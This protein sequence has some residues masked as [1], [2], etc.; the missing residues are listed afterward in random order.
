[1]TA[2]A[3]RVM[4]AT[5]VVTSAVRDTLIPMSHHGLQ[6]RDATRFCVAVYAFA[7]ILIDVAYALHLA[8]GGTSIE[9]LEFASTLFFFMIWAPLVPLVVLAARRFPFAPGRRLRTIEIHLAL[10]LALS[11]VTLFAHKLLFCPSNDWFGCVTYY[12]AEA[13]LARWIGLDLFLYAAVLAGIWI[14]DSIDVKRQTELRASTIEL[15]IA[16]A[17]LKLVNTQVNP[18]FLQKTFDWLASE[19]RRDPARA[20]ALMTTVADYLRLC[21]SA[22]GRADSTKEA[23]VEIARARMAIENARDLPA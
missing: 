23:E 5:Y 1:M 7:A 2:R 14:L 12:R 13:W 19:S 15:E 10:G 22:L 11:F 16:N 8:A 3:L 6:A 9:R 17:Q 20:E 4:N 18:V 21:L